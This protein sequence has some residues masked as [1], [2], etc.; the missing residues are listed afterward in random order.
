MAGVPRRS[1]SWATV[2]LVTTLGAGG[3]AL[4]AVM[5]PDSSTATIASS[6][7]QVTQPPS[8]PT[9][10]ALQPSSTSIPPGPPHPPAPGSVTVDAT[11]WAGHGDL[12][13]VSSGR[14]GVLSDTGTLTEITGPPGGGFD[15]NPAWSLDDQWLAFLHTGPANGFD[16]PAPTLWLAKAGSSH[17]R[18][19]TTNGIGMFAW[20][21]VG[22]VLAYT[23]A[24]EYNFPGGVP[25]DVWIDDPGSPPASV[26]VGTG[27]GVGSIAWAPDGTELAYDDS[28]F[29]HPATASSPATLPVGRVGIVS[30][31]GGPAVTAYQL[32]ESG[33]DLAAWWP[34][35]G[36]LLFWEDPG[37]SGSDSL[38][39]QTLYSLPAGGDRPVALASSLLGPTWLAPEPGG[40]TVAVVAGKGRPIWTL[41]RDVDLCR[42]PAA[43]CQAVTIP[44]G[45]VG[46]APRWSS[47]GMLVFAVASATGPF[48]P[49]GEAYYSSGWM[50]QWNATSALWT[51]VPGGRPN[52][53]S[54]SPAGAL[55]AVPAKEGSTM[56]VVADDALW[57]AD[58][59]S[60]A[61]AVRVAGPLYSTMDPS[62]YYGEVDWSGTFA[63][64]DAV[65][66]GQ[67]ST[68]L[69]DEDLDLP[70][71][72][73]P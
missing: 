22:S 1:V 42:F 11:A 61:P 69:L 62:G 25:E 16:V 2:A 19:V 6:R 60:G 70:E 39:G 21:P 73:L 67:E 18:E 63:W 26:P 68:Q 7:Q 41:G 31:S 28:V 24:P 23:V 36:G 49:N 50:A 32:T 48:G 58:P 13:F 5:A 12:A 27:A 17:A 64:S 65:G 20:S 46:L 51:T 45:S 37:F 59:R 4:G 35:G 55:L 33:I 40:D 71:A 34:E 53:L 44:S 72:Q 8:S 56:V 3:A 52:P 57:L 43:T 38:T 30:A 10:T 15:S 29:G 54:L 47:S 9:T 14:L 66:L